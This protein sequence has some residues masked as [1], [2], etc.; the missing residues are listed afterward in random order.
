MFKQ[1][2]ISDAKDVILVADFINE[3]IVDEM[4]IQNI[5]WELCEACTLEGYQILYDPNLEELL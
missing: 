5:S 3:E 2:L 1:D 4:I